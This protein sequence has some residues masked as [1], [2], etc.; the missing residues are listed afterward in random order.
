MK[1]I[2][3]LLLSLIAIN[4]YAQD[5]LVRQGGGVEK[6]KVLEVTP[7]EV[8]YM[9]NESATDSVFTELC[10]NLFYIRY[11]DG[12]LQTFNYEQKP[13]EID[14]TASKKYTK[15]TSLIDLRGIDDM[16]AL[17]QQYGERH[18]YKAGDAIRRGT[19]CMLGSIG[20][21]LASGTCFAIA[22]LSDGKDANTPLFIAG[23]V[24]AAISLGLCV[25]SIHYQYKSGRELRLSAGEVIYRF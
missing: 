15:S 14:T 8:K 7:T 24:T 2:L 18:L 4:A 10:T 13:E 17:K 9:K 25:L 22:A 5:I 12:K 19:S 11:K 16:N 3:F 20:T 1:K 6:V 23:G 21:S